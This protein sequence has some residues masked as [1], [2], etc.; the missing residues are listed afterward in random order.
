LLL[1]GIA[2]YLS[3]QELRKSKFDMLNITIPLARLIVFSTCIFDEITQFFEPYR[4]ADITD[5]AAHILGI[6]VFTRSAEK[7]L[8]SV[9]E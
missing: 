8:E 3:H 4:S 1:L 2:A 9:H 7:F 6:I 5:L